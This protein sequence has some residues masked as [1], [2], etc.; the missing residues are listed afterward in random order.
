[1][2]TDV[3]ERGNRLDALCF[4]NYIFHFFFRKLLHVFFFSFAASPLCYSHI[5][6]SNSESIQVQRGLKAFHFPTGSVWKMW[7]VVTITTGSTLAIV[8]LVGCYYYLHS[9]KMEKNTGTISL[10]YKQFCKQE[11]IKLLLFAL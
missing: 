5:T 11:V 9:Q 1:M 2:L 10:C 4:Q 3:F 8:V 6:N 7:M